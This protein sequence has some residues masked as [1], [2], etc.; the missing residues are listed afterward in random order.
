MKYKFVCYILPSVHLKQN[1]LLLLIIAKDVE[2]IKLNSV[3]NSE[4]HINCQHT[5]F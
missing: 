2:N 5:H 1:T 4:Q 3:C